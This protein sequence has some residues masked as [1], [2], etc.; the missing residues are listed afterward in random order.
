MSGTFQSFLAGWIHHAS[1]LMP[2][3]APTVNSYKRYQS[4][5]WAPTTLAWSPDNRTA[6][7]RVVGRDRSLRIEC[8]L[9]GADTNPY[10]AYAAALA[11]G[12]DGLQRSLTPPP[13][14]GGDA[15]AS[16]DLP[17]VP[18]SL[19][20][21]VSLLEEGTLARTAFGD[22]VVEHYLHH[23]RTEVAA[24]ERAVTDWERIRY[25]ERI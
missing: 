12:I 7:F 5:S 8:R 25:F 23:W 4:Q 19:G 9:P 10:L 16:A 11:A 2:F 20:A 24:Y 14:V 18:A 3:M 17:T 21:A 15:Y 22:D 6:G 13:A 1:E